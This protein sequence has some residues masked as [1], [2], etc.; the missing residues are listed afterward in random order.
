MS[1]RPE[2]EAALEDLER[3][4]AQLSSADIGDLIAV[5]NALEDRADAVARIARL[6]G[7]AT[8][9]D[10]ST[11]A[12][13]RLSKAL[14]DGEETT[15]RLLTARRQ[16]EESLYQA[17]ALAGIADCSPAPAPRLDCSA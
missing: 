11:A 15:R 13:E 17:R 9:G 7:S 8:Q 16:L 3:S 4:T 14:I 6:A 2:L 12:I 5:T 10:V 1:P